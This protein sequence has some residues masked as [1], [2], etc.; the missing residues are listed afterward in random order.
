MEQDERIEQLKEDARRLSGGQM[1]SFGIDRLPKDMAE[2]FLKRM[3]AFETAPDTTDFES[4]TADRVPLPPPDEVSDRDMGVVLWRVIF[5]L[6]I[7]RVFL[8]ATN[9]LSD[10]EL[11]LV[12][13][14]TVLREEH[15]AI[16]EG[17]SGA[18][19]VYVP[20]DDPESTNYLS[21]Y[22]DD[23]T[24]EAWLKDAPDAT[25]PPR[26]YPR[27][28]RDEDVPRPYDDPQ[29]AEAREWLRTTSNPSALATNRFGHTSEALK[30]V[31]QLYDAGASCV[32]VDHIQ[33]L[34]D[35]NGE[36]YADEL[37]IVFPYDARRHDLFDIIEHEGRPDAV[38][39]QQHVIDQG[40][41]SARLWWD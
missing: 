5:G 15:A 37:V 26:R 18:Y 33:M 21:Y 12:L 10:R 32:I 29:C 14:N 8:E 39:D 1:R 7:H 11:Y 27:F 34:A 20:G 28:D 2:E 35:D 31:E 30:F 16:P 24:R 19:H 36:P 13:W 38:D 40:R 22:A 9:H 41:G 17:D 25:L 6:A 3:I 23:E 4:L